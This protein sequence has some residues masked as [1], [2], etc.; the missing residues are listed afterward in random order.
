M[1]LYEYKCD[2]CDKVYEVMQKFSD[3]EIK[4]CE[5]CGSEVYKLM[6]RTSFQLK[7]SG[8]YASDYKKSTSSSSV[9]ETKTVAAETKK[10]ETTP[11]VATKPTGGGCGSGSCSS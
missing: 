3:P 6:S 4:L 11:A 2:K 8:W 7:G 5:V 9:S 10:T 1:P